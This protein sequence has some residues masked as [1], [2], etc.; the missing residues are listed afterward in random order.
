M[1]LKEYECPSWEA[2]S[3]NFSEDP[4]NNPVGFSWSRTS[5]Y[6]SNGVLISLT[7]EIKKNAPTGEYDITLTTNDVVTNSSDKDID[8]ELMGGKISIVKGVP[9]DSNGDGAVNSKDAVRLAQYLAGW[10]V[11]MEMSSADCNGDGAVNSKDAVRLAQYLA[12]WK[13][14]LK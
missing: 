9:G 5:N 10:K 13:V 4:T 12:G 6:N 1:S 3:S 11:S 14:E 2:V 8:F 7:F